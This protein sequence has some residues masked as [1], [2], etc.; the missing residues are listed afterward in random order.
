MFDAD[1]RYASQMLLLRA[2]ARM[3]YMMPRAMSLLLSLCHD[4]TLSCALRA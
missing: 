2:Y 4:D 3:P 1:A